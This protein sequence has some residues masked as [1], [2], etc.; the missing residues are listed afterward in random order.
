MTITP[1]KGSSPPSP[2]DD[3]SFG[4]HISTHPKLNPTKKE[5]GATRAPMYGRSVLGQ[6]GMGYQLSA[7]G[8]PRAKVG[9]GTIDWSTVAAVS[10]SDVTLANGGVVSVGA[11]YLPAGSTVIRIT[12]VVNGST[13]GMYGPFDPTTPATDGRQTLAANADCYLLNRDAIQGN[14]KDDYPELIYGGRVWLARI[15]NTGASA[16]SLTGGPT[17]A[18]IKSTFP[19]LE[20]VDGN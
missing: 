12:S 16:H 6:I 8:N 20:L 13:V 1:A 9:G 4:L 15:L 11:K 5:G 2:P 19:L 3:L 14:P 18:E 7:D 10:G 17:L